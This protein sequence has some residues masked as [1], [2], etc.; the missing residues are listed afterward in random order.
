L[1]RELNEV[2]GFKSFFDGGIIYFIL[3]IRVG[4]GNEILA[5]FEFGLNCV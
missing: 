4:C 3:L 1:A 2:F 5:G